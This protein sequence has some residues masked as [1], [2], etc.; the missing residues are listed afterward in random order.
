MNVMNLETRKRNLIHEVA[1][2][3]EDEILEKVEEIQKES[4]D[5]WDSLSD[6]DKGAIEN[7]LQQL[8][9]GNYL[10]HDQIRMRIKKKFNF[11]IMPYPVRFSTRA[12]T[13]YESILQ[14][15]SDNFGI[16]KALDVDTHYE[17]IIKQISSNPEMYLTSLK[18]SEIRRCV[19]SRQTSLYYLFT[20]EFVES[21]SF[22]A[23]RMDSHSFDF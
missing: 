20:G 12:Y 19:I 9:S 15:V 21:I 4:S 22:R 7:G 8:N 10:Q 3:Q 5:W 13:E 14:Y 17:G 16:L 2:V 23:N 11:S 18:Y 1:T 6:K